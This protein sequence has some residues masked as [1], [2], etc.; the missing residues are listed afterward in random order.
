MHG[1]INRSF[2]CFLRDTYGV[3]LWATVAEA[4]GLPAEGFEAMMN[5]DD[6]LTYAYLLYTSR[7]V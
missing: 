5:Y 4:A 1:L 6:G 7:C 2:Q 3:S